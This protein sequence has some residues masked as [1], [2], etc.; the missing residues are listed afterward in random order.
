M[1]KVIAVQAV[2]ETDKKKSVTIQTLGSYLNIAHRFM[3]V[4]S[5]RWM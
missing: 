1:Y 5:L 3:F 2:S 4:S